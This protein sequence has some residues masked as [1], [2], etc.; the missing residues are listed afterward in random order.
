MTHRHRLIVTGMMAV[1]C[2]FAVTGG[3]GAGADDDAAERIRRAREALQAERPSYEQLAQDNATLRRRVAELEKQVGE[4][5]QEVRQLREKYEPQN[6]PAADA[7]LIEMR[8]GSVGRLRENA[9]YTESQD[10]PVAGWRSHVVLDVI[11]EK[12]AIVRWTVRSLFHG[13]RRT[14]DPFI[15]RGLATEGWVT[16]ARVDLH[17]HVFRVTGTETYETAAGGQRTVFVLEPVTSPSPD[18]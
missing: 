7:P 16:D 5:R 3:T 8:L 18:S 14:G 1:A 12:S 4:L 13:V 2:L 17:Q 11:D 6:L 9:T 10:G 15:V